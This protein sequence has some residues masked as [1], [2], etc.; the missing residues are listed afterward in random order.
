MN[1]LPSSFRQAKIAV[2]DDI[3]GKGRGLVATGFVAKGELLVAFGGTVLHAA[4]LEA[5]D[6]EERLA[7]VQ[8]DEDLYLWSPSPGPG[9]WIN[10][11]CEP[12]AGLRGQIVLIAL[13]DIQPGE[14][15]CYDYAMS[16]GSDYDEFECHC[17]S[18]LCRGVVTGNDWRRSELVAR[19]GQHF[20]PYLLRRI[21]RQSL[22]SSVDSP[23]ESQPLIG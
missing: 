17:G 8:V 3:P 22:L 10:H 5:L 21:Y 13:R 2:R 14:E 7:V 4:Q 6:N 15:V 1:H 18:S 9:D 23:A 12:N 19:Y 11:S 20:S 16:D